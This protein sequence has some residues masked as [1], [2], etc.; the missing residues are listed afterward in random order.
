MNLE[1]NKRSIKDKVA[2]KPELKEPIDL[3]SIVMPTGNVAYE[4]NGGF[5]LLGDSGELLTSTHLSKLKGK[6]YE[7]VNFQLF[8]KFQVPSVYRFWLGR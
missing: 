3:K 5:Y 1:K 4:K 6:Y 8:C 7:L 2:E